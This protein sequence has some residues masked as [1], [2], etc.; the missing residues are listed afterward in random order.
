MVVPVSSAQ[1]SMVELL[2]SLSHTH[3]PTS[4]H[5][6]GPSCHQ[7]SRM[8]HNVHN[9]HPSALC[10]TRDRG[11]TSSIAQ[12][13]GI[14]KLPLFFLLQL[15]SQ[16]ILS[17]TPQAAPCQVS[18]H[19]NGKA[20]HTDVKSKN[21]IQKLALPKIGL[22]WASRPQLPTLQKHTIGWETA[23]LKASHLKE[24]KLLWSTQ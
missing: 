17:E 5:T 21:K 6:V 7:A 3:W 13:T 12:K 23:L 9:P 11:H 4:R 24:S 10:P 8:Q 1:F 22:R 19:R 14:S 20:M 2:A 15:L 16:E 18:S